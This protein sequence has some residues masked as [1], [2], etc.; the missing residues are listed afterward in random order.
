[1]NGGKSV[2]HASFV[3]NDFSQWSN[4]FAFKQSEK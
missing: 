3:R 4:A 2:S 1:V